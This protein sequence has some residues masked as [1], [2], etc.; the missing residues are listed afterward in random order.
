MIPP[1]YMWSIVDWNV[2]WHMTVIIITITKLWGLFINSGNGRY[3]CYKYLLP[4]CGLLFHFLSKIFWWTNVLKFSILFP[5]SDFCGL[6]LKNLSYI[7]IKIFSLLFSKIFIAL[8]FTFR[9]TIY[10]GLIFEVAHRIVFFPIRIFNW[11][12]TI[13]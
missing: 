5:N 4:L 2:M 12:C 3:M 6:F 7:I 10:L 9:P 8:P 11:S 1:S 13:F